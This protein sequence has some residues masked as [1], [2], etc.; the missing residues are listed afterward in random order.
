MKNAKI[1]FVRRKNCTKQTIC[2][3]ISKKLFKKDNRSLE[4]RSDYKNRKDFIEKIYSITVT[5]EFL[6]VN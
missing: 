4:K 3:C 1:R 6:F 5:M 2:I